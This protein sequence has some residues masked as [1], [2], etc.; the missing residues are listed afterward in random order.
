MDS[1]TQVCLS[2][3]PVAAEFKE[4]GRRY[5]R[6]PVGVP[7][8]L[9]KIADRSKLPPL[10]DVKGTDDPS[11]DVIGCTTCHYPHAGKNAFLLRWSLAEL[12]AACLKCHPDVSPSGPGPGKGLIARR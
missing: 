4:T 10:V 6:H 12:S 2:C 7:V 8:A 9:G 1:A 11:D 5:V 3:H